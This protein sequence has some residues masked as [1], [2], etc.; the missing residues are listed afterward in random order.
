MLARLSADRGTL[1]DQGG[2]SL[3]DPLTHQ[4]QGLLGY[5]LNAVPSVVVVNLIELQSVHRA[6]KVHCHNLHW[7]RRPDFFSYATFSVVEE[8]NA[9]EHYAVAGF[10]Q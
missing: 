1:A 3:Q 2:G 7:R 10:D 5:R 4:I 6:A 8:C 9:G